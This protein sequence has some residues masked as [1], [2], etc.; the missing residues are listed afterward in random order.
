MKI[1]Q[2]TM[3]GFGPYRG[4]ETVDLDA[5]DDDG[6]FLIT[7]RTGAGKTSILDAITYALFGSVPRYEGSAGEKVRSDYIGPTDPCRVTVELSTADGRFTVTRSPAYQRPKQRGTGTTTAPPVFELA[8]QV[9]DGWEVVESKTGN[10]EVRIE[11]IV[12]LTAK[13][14]LQVI[15]LAQ[16]Q[17]Q[18]FLVATSDKRRELLRMLFDTRRFS[19]YSET[20][21]AR[22]RDLAARLSTSSTAVVSHTTSLAAETDVALPVGGDPVTGAGVEEWV[23]A[24]VALHEESLAVAAEQLVAAETS[25]SAA[26]Q[27]FDEQRLIRERQDR[28]ASVLR[29]QADLELAR[30]DVEEARLRLAEARRADRVWHRV[31]AAQ[32]ARRA[33]GAAEQQHQAA[34]EA[35]T[36]LLPDGPTAADALAPLV[37]QWSELLGSLRHSAD[38]ERSVVDLHE[39]VQTATLA[40]QA[41]DEQALEHVAERDGLRTERDA[42]RESLPDLQRRSAALGPAEQ[43]LDALRTRLASAR[44]AERTATELAA[45]QQQALAAGQAVTTASSLR[46][47][48]RSQQRAG[49]AGAL[50]QTL[51]PEQPCAVCGSLTHPAPAQLTEGHVDDTDVERAEAAYDRAVSASGEADRTVTALATRL[52]AEQEAAGDG[53]AA[54][55]SAGAIE[56]LVATAASAV[57]DAE[58]AVAE[59]EAGQQRVDRLGE[60]ID[61]LTQQIDSSHARR[62]ELVAAQAA[63]TTSHDDTVRSLTDARGDHETVAARLVAV[64]SH[65]QAGRAL[66]T[67]A[68]ARHDAAE[69]AEAATQLLAA[70]L[71]EHEFDTPDAVV[72]ARL[73]PPDQTTL[74]SRISRHDGQMQSVATSLASDEMHDLPADPVDPTPSREALANA[75]EAAKIAVAAESAARQRLATVRRR[76]ADI[77]SALAAAAGLSAEH[78]VVDRLASTVRGQ[79]PNTMKMALETFALAAELEEIVRAANARLTT[80]TG[81]R[82]A[83]LHSDAL[84]GRGAQSGLALDVLDAYTGDTRPPQSLSGGEKFQASLALAL[85][86]A[87]V[88]TNRAGGIR[89]DTLFIDEG[90]GSLDSDTLETT[91]ATLDNLREGGRTIGLI[92]HVEAMKESIP[93]QLFV[94]QTDGGW[95]TIRT[96]TTT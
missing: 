88:L 16:G 65:V 18:E 28:R 51:R 78:E 95:S 68:A 27:V 74:E 81:G 52:V 13:Q 48:V 58:A 53:D 33:V 11:E 89:L 96:T 38:R 73:A 40:L 77:R 54:T 64:T 66:L 12:R 63:A 86:L 94:D 24:L 14:F 60:R 61:A 45:A 10:A 69:H 67:S 85:G 82:Y 4:T 92:S 56:L 75:D 21:D 90:F 83:F 36:Q 59:V 8:R 9:G 1:H 91:M 17:F 46:D 15:L 3:T 41:F 6:I 72:A 35:F 50:A 39:A 30:P 2:V 31:E 55:T 84:A 76:A 87:E 70:A 44:S 26:Q 29:H 19:D 80:M 43:R 49:F 5:F 23:D 47:E 25:R 42:V 71:V 79:G 32:S 93:A 57:A 7:G 22:A 34:L 37:Q 20:L 62:S